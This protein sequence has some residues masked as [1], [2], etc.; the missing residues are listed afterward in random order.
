MSGR[1]RT[2]TAALIA[3]AVVA[4]LGAVAAPAAQAQPDFEVSSSTSVVC[5]GGSVT[6]T[7]NYPNQAAALYRDGEVW[8]VGQSGTV[9]P[10]YWGVGSPEDGYGVGQVPG[11]PDIIVTFVVYDQPYVE[12]TPPDPGWLVEG[13]VSV[14]FSGQC[15]G[16]PPASWFQSYGRHSADVACLAGWH[17]SWAQ[18]MNDGAGGWTCDR[19]LYYDGS[20]AMWLARSKDSWR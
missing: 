8:G 13:S 1:W 7:T 5:Q 12:D 3:G 9:P 17:P 20:T 4:A 6:F 16:G 19:E 18:W 14:V 10:V 11:G 15:P 2:T